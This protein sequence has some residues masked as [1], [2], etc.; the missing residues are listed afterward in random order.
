[1]TTSGW[2]LTQLIRVLAEIETAR[3]DASPRADAVAQTQ[4][5][6]YSK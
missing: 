3:G 2:A 5:Q 4:Q 6:E 1:M